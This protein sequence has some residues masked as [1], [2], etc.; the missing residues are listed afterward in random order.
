VN[1][2]ALS[3]V[4]PLFRIY[5]GVYL[6][7]VLSV[8]IGSAEALWSS[9]GLVPD[10]SLNLT[11]GVFPNI[12]NQLDSPRQIVG[13]LM[14][15]ITFT[16]LFTI[17]WQRRIAAVLIW[18]GWTCLLNRNNMIINPSFHYIGWLILACSL[19]PPG[20]RWSVAKAREN[21]RLPYEI[22]FGAWILTSVG[23]F[24]SGFDKLLSVSWV[25]GTALLKIFSGPLGSPLGQAL[26]TS[27]PNG[28][29]HILTWMTIALEM[30]I[31]PLAL[32]GK[33]RKWSWL[34]ATLFQAGLMVF[35]SIPQITFGML[36]MHIF[37]FN[38]S[39]FP[40][41]FVMPSKPLI[42]TTDQLR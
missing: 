13:F 20:E 18:Y 6:L 34:A 24:L 29:H 4:F 3:I 40:G 7:V 31:L 35:M 11:F 38:P 16:V 10:A 37:L 28:T 36:S 1:S 2:S 22:I 26:V 14:A 32:F 30:L 27:V 21:W 23:Y 8:S 17:G 9:N 25:D 15:L 42:A 5:L 41:I 12:L 39:W 33:T 19:I